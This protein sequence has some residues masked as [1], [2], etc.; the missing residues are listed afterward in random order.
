M[1]FRI[2]FASLSIATALS[3][4]SPYHV[5]SK[6]PLG[7]DGGWDYVTVDAD[8]RRVYL[9][10]ST[11]VVVLDA[12]TNAVVGR[13]LGLKG[14]HGVAIAQEFSRG[15]ISNGQSG[16]VTVFDTKTL[17]KVGDELKVE[18]NPDAI[19]YDPATGRVFVF[20]GGSSSAT[21][22]DAELA[23]VV[24]TVNLQGKPEF[25]VSD[26]ANAI[27]VNL[28]DKS[29]VARID[30]RKL[31]VEQLFPLAPCQE[32]SG[33]AMDRATRRLFVG[34]GNNMMAVLSADD[35]KLITSMPICSGVDA[36]AFD[37]EAA[38]IFH[39]CGDGTVTVVHEDSPDKYTAQEPLQTRAGSRTM[40]IDSKTH[41]LFLP[42]A[43]FEAAAPV[44]EGEKPARRKILP[45]TFGLL[46]VEK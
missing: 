14:V 17:K 45:G 20:N 9:A 44:K 28:E 26:G 5:G 40:G 16:S 24:G 13:I 37:S 3:A 36:T 29:M 22:I 11:E 27:F 18:K 39:S 30:T 34:C 31:L 8:S 19:V 4:A 1:R 10:H 15:F 32:P 41:K 12:D 21:A 35:G 7:G 25:A 23:A 38:L 42:T 46:I 2:L 33:I 6:I 43:D